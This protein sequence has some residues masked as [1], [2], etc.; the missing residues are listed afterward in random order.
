M[1]LFWGGLKGE[2][3]WTQYVGVRKIGDFSHS[4]SYPT[5]WIGI[6]ER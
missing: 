2:T 6:Q 3:I 1:D 5:D 4:R